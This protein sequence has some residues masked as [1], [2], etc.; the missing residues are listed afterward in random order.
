MKRL[1]LMTA[2][3][4]GIAQAQPRAK[5]LELKKVKIDHHL[6]HQWGEIRAELTFKTHNC[7]LVANPGT[8]TLTFASRPGLSV[9]VEKV[10]FGH[11]DE[12]GD[13]APATGA[14]IAKA[15]ELSVALKLSATPTVL[16]GEHELQ[17]IVSYQTVNSAG[18]VTPESLAIAIPYKVAE[19]L[20]VRG[21]HSKFVPGLQDA[22]RSTLEIVGG[23]VLLPFI[24]PF[25]LIW[26][27]L[28]GQCP[29]C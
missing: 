1:I 8:P 7:H 23:I 13:G 18:D 15:K 2:L 14:S 19:P 25:V 24:L 22:G 9:N 21:E 10:R 16:V 17:G 20:P 6:L 29:D 28:S 11:T 3:L 4:A 26:C 5:C 27:P 12:P